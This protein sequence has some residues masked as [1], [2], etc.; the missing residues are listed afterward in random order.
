VPDYEGRTPPSPTAREALVWVPRLA[1]GPAYL[2]SEY[3]V[4]RPV[5]GVVRWGEDHYVWRRIYELFTWDE[6]RGAIYPNATID[7]GLRQTAGMSMFW[8]ELGSPGNMLKA[9]ASLGVNVVSVSARDRLLAFRD[10]TGALV[11]SGGYTRR[12]DGLYFGLG[13]DTRADD[14]TF[15]GFTTFGGSIGLEG[16]LG[17]FSH[18]IFD[19]GYREATFRASSPNSPDIATRFGGAGQPPLPPGFDGYQLVQPRAVLVL[20]SRDPRGERGSSTD[21][22]VELA[23][24]YAVDPS[25]VQT[26]FASWGGQTCAFYDFSGVGHVLGVAVDARFVERLGTEAVP[27][28]EQPAL[29]GLETMRGFLAGRLRG[30]STITG[31]LQYRYPFSSFLD[32]ELFSEVGNAFGTHLDGFDVRQLFLSY[33]TAWRRVFTGDTSIALTLAFATSRFDDAQFSWFDGVRL[34]IGVNNGF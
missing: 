3:V 29:G 32:A 31:A 10:R 23:G 6:G 21:G 24:A 30:P 28:W 1:L 25:D 18:V 9:S 5:V 33:G 22:R 15:F 17:G 27:F 20:D 12:P 13:P 26:R 34:A 7:L 4:R 14:K 11:F 16:Y 19:L 8:R 2:A